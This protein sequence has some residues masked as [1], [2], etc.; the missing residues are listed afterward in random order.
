MGSGT[1]KTYT[2]FARFI[3]FGNQRK[4]FGL[5]KLLE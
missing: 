4:P 1:G 2:R 5:R 3:A